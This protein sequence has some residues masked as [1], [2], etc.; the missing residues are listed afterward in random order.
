VPCFIQSSR[1]SAGRGAT[2]QVPKNP[3]RGADIHVVVRSARDKFARCPGA[4]VLLG[5]AGS[6]LPDGRK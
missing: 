5:A 2:A 1:G 4:K 6:L 3:M